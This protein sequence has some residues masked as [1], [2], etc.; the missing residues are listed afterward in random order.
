MK[1]CQRLAER[2][3]G[4]RVID[5][6]SLGIRVV[7]ALALAAMPVISLSVFA[8]LT[9]F[10]GNSVDFSVAYPMLLGHILP[11]ALALILLLALPGMLAKGDFLARWKRSCAP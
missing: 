7:R 10:A 11:F 5:M 4:L 1:S 6:R 2:C 3:T 9:V 8:T